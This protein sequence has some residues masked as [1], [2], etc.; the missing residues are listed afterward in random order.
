MSALW[1]EGGTPSTLAHFQNQLWCTG[2]LTVPKR[3]GESFGVRDQ[4]ESNCILGAGSCPE[5][6]PGHAHGQVKE[7]SR[8]APTLAKAP[9]IMGSYPSPIHWGTTDKLGRFSLLTAEELLCSA[10]PHLSLHQMGL[11]QL[12]EKKGDTLN[13]DIGKM[14]SK[15]KAG[16]WRSLL[17]QWELSLMV[18]VAAEEGGKNE[19]RLSQIGD[20][21]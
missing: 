3:S 15:G 9:S 1:G 7:I 5:C 6:P 20:S 4:I 12:A 13:E 10:T 19:T 8:F 14:H 11:I 16:Y 2:A 21:V 18:A 17:C